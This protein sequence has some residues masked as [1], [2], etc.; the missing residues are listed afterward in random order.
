MGVHFKIFGKV[1]HAFAVD[2][3]QRDG[4]LHEE[5]DQLEE[6]RQR[7]THVARTSRWLVEE[8]VQTDANTI[9][10]FNSRS[11]YKEH[12]TRSPSTMVNETERAF[13]QKAT[14]TTKCNNR[15]YMHETVIIVWQTP[16][17]Q[18]GIVV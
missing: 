15:C 5:I 11:F 17:D 18:K 8:L 10:A 7:N 13:Q 1:N 9:E 16:Q 4:V 2:Q 6:E 3:S 14:T 12:A